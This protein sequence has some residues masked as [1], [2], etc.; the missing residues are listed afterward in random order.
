MNA[1][2]T[3]RLKKFSCKTDEL[4]SSIYGIM[5][6]G[7]F[8]QLRR[9]KVLIKNVTTTTKD[10]FIILDYF[11]DEKGALYYCCPICTDRKIVESLSENFISE[12]LAKCVHSDTC[13]ILFGDE[14][15]V[16]KIDDDVKH[17]IEIISNGTNYMVAVHPD[18]RM[19]KKSGVVVLTTKT[20]TPKCLT[21]SSRGRNACLHIK[22]HTGKYQQNE[23]DS[24]DSD[25][26][27]ELESNEGVEK[28][29][30]MKP[31]QNNK[32]KKENIVNVFNIKINFI[33]NLEEEAKNKKIRDTNRFFDDKIVIP[34]HLGP[35]DK[36]ES[37]GRKF[38]KGRNILWKE[39]TNVVVH[40]VKEVDTKDIIMLYRPTTPDEE[41]GETC[42]CKKYFTGSDER[43]L[44][45]TAANDFET[46][47]RAKVVH[48]VSYE[49]LNQFLW[50]LLMGGEKLDAFLKAENYMKSIFFGAEKSSF[51]RNILSKAFEIFL[52]ALQ[53]PDFS[54][55]CF[56]CPQELEHGEHAEDYDDIE[57]HVVDGIQM[58]CKT[59]DCKGHIPKEYF[60]EETNGDELVI[61]V[62]SEDRTCLNMKKARNIV[63][64]M[65]KDMRNKK[66]MKETIAKLENIKNK[67]KGYNKILDCLLLVLKRISKT[68]T[69]LPDGYMK[70]L[71]ELKLDTPISA[72]LTPYTSNRE[73][74]NHFYDY[75]KQKKKIFDDPS[76]TEEFINSF[77]V[78]MNIMQSILKNEH[79]EKEYKNRYLP[80]DVANL[81][82]EMIK[83]RKDV[84][85]YSVLL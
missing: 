19:N 15:K 5:K 59:N 27:T 79:G 71:H 45:V 80:D 68:H 8:Q 47:G 62:E 53:F 74:Y 51:H 48:L 42:N 65:L 76:L 78:I 50:Q 23:N 46:I 29:L 39:S 11:R 25:D 81:F 67:T 44:R 35:E 82:K 63:A 60:E 31:A 21:C 49:K 28:T 9:N 14:L 37:H 18:P 2:I 3:E 17:L 30:R 85:K 36:C 70:L 24:T 7:K 83:L 58:G 40:H 52:H 26:S 72:L 4:K 54:N 10:K 43:L 38:A 84:K 64:D 56:E 61:G 73:L 77:P 12:N 33:P 41:T 66:K 57:Y 69:I 22:I 20:L 32:S 55:F 6:E 13:K 16:E 75:L 34:K 1:S